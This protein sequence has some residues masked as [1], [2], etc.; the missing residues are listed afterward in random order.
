[1][2]TNGIIYVD[3]EIS[4]K[5]ITDGSSNTFLIGEMSWVKASPVRVWIVGSTP[6]RD[7]V[8]S[9]KNVFYP[10]NFA[11]RNAPGIAN[12]DVSF[13]SEHPGGAHFAR[14]DGSADLVSENTDL[15]VLRAFASRADGERVEL[16]EEY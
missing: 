7:C 5:H 8:Y 14:A 11:A 16:E 12:N 10:M 6:S 9:A 1:M 3:S 13:G 15:I 2:A 4:F